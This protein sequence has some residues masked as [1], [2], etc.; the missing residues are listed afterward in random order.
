MRIIRRLVI[1][2]LRF[3]FERELG[4]AWRMLQNEHVTKEIRLTA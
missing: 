3:K 4:M 1:L 2:R